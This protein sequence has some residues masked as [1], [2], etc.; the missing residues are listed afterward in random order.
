MSNAELGEIRL[1]GARQPD[2]FRQNDPG[3]SIASIISSAQARIKR[4][5]VSISRVEGWQQK[6]DYSVSLAQPSK[7][8]R[9]AVV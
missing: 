1:S 2:Y 7:L 4:L 8:K 5:G 9:P 3:E 6:K